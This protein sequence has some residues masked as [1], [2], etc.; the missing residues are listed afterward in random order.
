MATGVIRLMRFETAARQDPAVRAWFKEQPSDLGAIAR[1][2][3]QMMRACGQD[4]CELVHDDQP[5]ACVRGAAFA[6]VDAFTAHVNVGFFQ[7]VALDDPDGLLQGAGKYMRHVKVHPDRP[8]DEQ[9]LAR[10]IQAAYAD[11]RRRVGTAML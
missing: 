11:V 1:R 7:G 8:V 10:L 4:V 3:F 9:A 6:Y 5:T 2:W